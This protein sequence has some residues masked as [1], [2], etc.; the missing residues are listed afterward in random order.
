MFDCILINDELDILDIR[1][2][3]LDSVIEKFVIVESDLT[4]SG[5]P[6]PLHFQENWSRFE[7]FKDKIIHLVYHAHA[8]D[9]NNPNQSWSNEG[10]QRNKF[11][12]ALSVQKPSDGFCLVC[13]VDEIPRPDKLLYAKHISNETGMPVALSMNWS[14]YFLNYA[15]PTSRQFRGPYLYKPDQAQAV[16]ARFN[17]SQYDPSYFRWHMCAPGYENDFP[18]LYE[19]GWHFSF[20]GGIEKV[21]RK[22]SSYAHTEWDR[23]DV[24]STDHVLRCM[25]RGVDLFNGTPDQLEIK[26]DDFLPEYV[27]NNQDKFK[28]YLL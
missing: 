17:Q 16:H 4:H 12:E 3:T 1:L 21:S 6:K 9:P 25:I 24:K 13:D 27:R 11:L 2:N 26:P 19:A 22:L 15:Y 8:V 23:E 28:K 14:L 7:K 20:M 18:T 10:Q 5:K